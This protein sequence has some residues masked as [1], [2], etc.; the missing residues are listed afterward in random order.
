MK[1]LSFIL[2]G[3]LIAMPAMAT[4]YDE[5]GTYDDGE[6]YTTYAPDYD[7]T[8]RE[9]D[10]RARDTYVGFR[11]HKNEH[12]AFDYDVHNGAGTTIKNDNFGFGM[13]IG[14]RLTDYVKLELE[15][16]YTGT[17]AT[18]HDTDF[19]YDIWSNMLNA[20][21]YKNFG[22]AVEPYFGVGIGFSGIWGDINGAYGKFGDSGFELSF[23]VSAGVNFALN[24]YIDLNLGARYVDYGKV[25]HH[26]ATTKID[27][28]EI[29]IGA[30]YKFGLL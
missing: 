21:I 13:H 14:N 2:L 5:Y 7:A 28:T 12:I 29:Y 30:A 19:D 4:D 3:A 1:K 16:L 11:I 6:S 10:T 22:G 23:A 17:S 9:T 25:A 18:K 24:K 20:Y 15:T 8:P 27:A 26:N